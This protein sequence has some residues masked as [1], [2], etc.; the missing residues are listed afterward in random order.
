Y[1]REHPNDSKDRQKKLEWASALKGEQLKKDET[2]KKE[3][4]QSETADSERMVD[5]RIMS[6]QA[7]TAHKQQ[8]PRGIVREY[9]IPHWQFGR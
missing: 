7:K 8:Q 1:Q 9:K 6:Q 5:E 2:D 3:G 4:Q